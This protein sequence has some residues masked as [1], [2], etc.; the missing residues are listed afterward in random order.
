MKKDAYYFSHDANAHTDPKVLRL[1]VELGWEG[2]GIFWALV[3]TL[4]CQKNYRI[5]EDDFN[6]LSMALATP[7]DNLEKVLDKCL[8][9]GLLEKKNGFIFSQSLLDRMAIRDARKKAGS[10]KRKPEAK[11]ETK[12]EAEEEQKES[13]SKSNSTKELKEQFDQFRVSYKGTK[14]GLNKEFETLKKHKDWKE[15]VPKL[16][17]ALQYQSQA[18]RGLDEA[19]DFCPN[20]KNLSTWM[21]QRCWEDEIAQ[22]L[23]NEKTKPNQDQ[24][25]KDQ[26]DK[27]YE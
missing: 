6:F 11:T 5:A 8:E 4:R 26:L 1:R 24:Y 14:G 7:A 3:E 17:Q 15:I 27:G 18:R 20:W 13:E 22:P 12:P 10:S 2:Y 9:V 16:E 23:E 21:N 19:G 25:K